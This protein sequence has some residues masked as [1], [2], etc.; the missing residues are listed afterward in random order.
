MFLVFG[1]RSSRRE[2]WT[3]WLI[4]LVF[5]LCLAGVGR[6]FNIPQITSFY[7]IMLFLPSL[8][9]LIRRLHDT[10]RSG[11]WCLIGVVPAIG[12]ICIFILCL[13]PGDTERNSYGDVPR[14]SN[15]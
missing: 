10:G 9:V 11:W 5:M 13:L 7:A 8:S 4:N 14:E 6:V 1:G 12:T 2:Y 3:F 15:L